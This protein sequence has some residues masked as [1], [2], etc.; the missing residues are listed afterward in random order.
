MADLSYQEKKTI[1][2]HIIQ[3][4]YVLNFS[5]N[6]FN[7]F[8]GGVTGLNIDN[9]KYSEDNSG[10]K[11]QRLLKFMELESDYVVGTLLKALFDELVD[12]NTRQGKVRSVGYYNSYNKISERLVSGGNV[13]EH[14]EAIQATND[15]KD[16]HALAKLIRES[17]NNNEPEA[18][19]DRLHIYL[20][21][22]L[23]ELCQSHRLEFKKEET[24]NGLFG[25]YIKKIRE[26]GFLESAMAEKI[27]QFSFQIMDA[28]NDIRNN[29]SYAHDN[30]VLNYDES[31]LIFSNIS[32]MVKFIQATEA[33]HKNEVIEQAD[34]DWGQF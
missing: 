7:D 33:K 20:I 28:F 23:K 10:S 18:A 16:F 32:S 2:E 6:S 17:I 26:K 3:Q 4:G 19:L 9:P 11:G 34:S 8:V 15:D 31:V 12:F 5:N 14:I 30:P 1:K 21:K 24:V 27:V 29:R 25:K 13:V 22:F